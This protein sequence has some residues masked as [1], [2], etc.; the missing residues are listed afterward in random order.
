MPAR[1][2]QVDVYQSFSP[3]TLAVRELNSAITIRDGADISDAD[4]R[5]TIEEALPGAKIS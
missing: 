5:K 3:R 4:L 2:L 1:W